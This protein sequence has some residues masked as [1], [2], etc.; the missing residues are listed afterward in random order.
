MYTLKHIKYLYSPE[1][2]PLVLFQAM[3]R[4]NREKNYNNT[5]IQYLQQRRQLIKIIK[6]LNSQL[7]FNSNTFFTSLYYMD[8]I[9]LNNL[10]IE[11]FSDF[12]LVG[13]SCL[14]VSSKFNENDSNFPEIKKFIAKLA[15]ITKFRYRFTNEDIIR[16]EI[17]VI[18]SLD[19]KLK[20]FSIYSFLVFFFAHG[21]ILSD[22][23]VTKN[24]SSS[25]NSID[26]NSKFLEKI[27]SIS[28]GI[29]DRFLDGNYIIIGND[30][31]L[32][33]IA[34][35]QK[36]I[37]VTRSINNFK[38]LLKQDST[39][40]NVF[41]ELY[42]INQNKS[43][44]F[45]KIE[46]IINNIYSVICR[47]KSKKISKLNSDYKK[48][49]SKDRFKKEK[50]VKKRSL[51]F[52]NTNKVKPLLDLELSYQPKTNDINQIKRKMLRASTY[53]LEA[54][55]MMIRIQRKKTKMPEEKENAKEQITESKTTDR[56]FQK[57][58]KDPYIYYYQ[59][60]QSQNYNYNN[61]YQNIP[62]QNM[63]HCYGV[64]Y[65]LQNNFINSTHNALASSNI[66]CK[67]FN[68][69]VFFTN[70][71]S[72]YSNGYVNYNLVKPK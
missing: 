57:Q 39:D 54:P 66:N 43:S 8:F 52:P 63:Y 18:K 20:R 41:K 58:N 44:F 55:S 65:N 35:L 71:G 26:S 61:L 32:V 19:Y 36:A 34:I 62:C 30:C 51:S 45:I 21:I 33:A 2:N 22:T 3:I 48:D 47:E 6:A 16:G 64:Y 4:E 11:K 28:R 67:Y 49:N 5:N 29:L 72:L 37:E 17:F 10:K 53:N 9:F 13:V 12:L 31:C 70:M 50:V 38:H 1:Q 68:G 59:N 24:Q 56:L 42:N 27:Y 25:I 14:L 7:Y 60:N 15:N 40:F 23:D 69:S 46:N